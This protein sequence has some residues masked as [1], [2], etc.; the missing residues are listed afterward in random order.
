MSAPDDHQS[1]Q[2]AAPLTDDVTGTG[3]FQIVLDGYDAI[4]D[5]LPRG[6]TLIACGGRTRTT[7]TFPGSSRI[8]AS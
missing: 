1:T 3:V 7:R 5:A 2:A 8:S 4:Y 6:E